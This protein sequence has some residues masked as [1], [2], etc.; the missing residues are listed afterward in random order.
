M[1][2]PWACG[3]RDAREQK[4]TVVFMSICSRAFDY[5]FSVRCTMILPCTEAPQSIAGVCVS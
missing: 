5:N 1:S 3:D 4:G 2:D